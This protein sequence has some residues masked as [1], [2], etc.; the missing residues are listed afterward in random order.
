MPDP[1]VVKTA[2]ADPDVTRSDLHVLTIFVR[3]RIMG[4]RF[5][6]FRA[7]DGRTP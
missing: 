3:L 5:G 4:D 1:W 7:G 2:H 6:Q